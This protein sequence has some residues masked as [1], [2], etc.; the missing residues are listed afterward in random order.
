MMANISCHFNS[1]VLELNTQLEI[2]IPD[3][4]KENE[5]IKV[6]Y[7]LHGYFGNHTDWT[8]M[9]SIE[10]YIS[11]YRVA[12]VMPSVNNSYY[13]DMVYGLNY[14][15]YMTEELPR[16]I[17]NT[18]PVSKQREDHYVC[19]LSMGGYGALKM[20]LTYPN[21]YK[22][23]ASL[24]GALN[25]DHIQTLSMTNGRKSQFEATFGTKPVKGTH[26]DL[27]Y[28]LSQMPKKDKESLNIFVGCGT[29]DFLYHDNV[30]FVSFLKEQK[31][32]C[33]Y[34]E[35]SGAHDWAFW[36][37]YIQKVIQWMFN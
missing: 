4:I 32:N 20:A 33:T 23:A 1:A 10:R 7:L 17:E 25:L 31:V 6:L 28:L 18:F 12:V 16:F 34:V 22:M 27:K 19:G 36:D 15:T 11:K 35:S 13:T 2:I 26:D 14:F 9:S 29:E 21:K 8:R 30:D 3:D 37:S 24:S 5:K